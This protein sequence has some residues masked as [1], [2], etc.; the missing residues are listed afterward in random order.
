MLLP[1]RGDE[2]HFRTGLKKIIK[3]TKL[4]FPLQVRHHVFV[5]AQSVKATSYPHSLWWVRVIHQVTA[6]RVPCSPSWHHKLKVRTMNISVSQE[7]IVI[8]IKLYCITD[9]Q[10]TM[11]AIMQG[12][13]KDGTQRHKAT[14]VNSALTEAKD[15]VIHL[16]AHVEGESHHT[17]VVDNENS[18]EIE[19]LAVLHY[20][21]SQRC[22]KVNVRYNDE[23][24]RERRRHKQPL[25]RPRVCNISMTTSLRGQWCR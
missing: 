11:K 2:T 13:K 21:W 17:E 20:L 3:K 24:L 22:D 6:K 8:V 12:K 10:L 25:L 7:Q 4:D 14:H 18:F 15:K 5:N 9:L 23:R 19:S 16:I 1:S